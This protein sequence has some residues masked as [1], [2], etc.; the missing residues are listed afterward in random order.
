MKTLCLFLFVILA[1]SAPASFKPGTPIDEISLKNGRVLKNV[2]LVS[3]ATTAAMAKWDGGRGT[4]PYSDLPDD[5]VKELKQFIPVPAA[6]ATSIGYKPA[7]TEYQKLDASPTPPNIALEFKHGATQEIR[8]QIFVTTKGQ[9]SIKL[10]GLEIFI[11]SASDFA[12]I[13]NWRFT[14]GNKR[15]LELL[16]RSDNLSKN[17]QYTAAGLAAR[18]A[19]RAGYNA[20]SAIPRSPYSAMTDADGRF[21]I[22]HDIAEPFIIFARGSR[23]V[24]DNTEYYVWVIP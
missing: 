13:R 2:Q 15:V 5:F 11:Y 24:I 20:W 10:G 21:R 16:K 22:E 23:E 18:F 4:I 12:A 8:G 6:A 1:A 19:L 9:N 3:F 7:L 14:E 17:E